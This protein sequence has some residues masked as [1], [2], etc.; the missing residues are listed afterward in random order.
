VDKS[1]CA[2][3]VVYFYNFTLRLSMCIKSDH[4]DIKSVPIAGN[5]FKHDLFYEFLNDVQKLDRQVTTLYF[6]LSHFLSRTSGAMDIR[7]VILC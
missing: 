3:F 2:R 5:D 4:S 1:F 7:I 6:Y